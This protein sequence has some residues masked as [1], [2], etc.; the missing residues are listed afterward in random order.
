MSAHGPGY[1]GRV[2]MPPPAKVEVFDTKGCSRPLLA[3][4]IIRAIYRWITL[5][6]SLCITLISLA[7]AAILTGCGQMGP[8]YMPTAEE[9]RETGAP[10]EESG[11]AGGED[12]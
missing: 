2:R 11:P 6:P 4:V 3:D 7:L 8:L 9:S 12:T 1:S 10:P 5:M